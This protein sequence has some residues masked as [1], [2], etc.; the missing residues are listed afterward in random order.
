MLKLKHGLADISKFYPLSQRRG[1]QFMVTFL[2]TVITLF[3]GIV[4][5]PV[6]M[7]TCCGKVLS[8]E[9]H[10]HDKEFFIFIFL[11]NIPMF[12]VVN[13]ACS[14]RSLIAG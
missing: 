9:I 12:C 4:N 3:S 10:L 8:E 13:P 11:I 2:P 5:L 1:I 6:A 7:T 14:L